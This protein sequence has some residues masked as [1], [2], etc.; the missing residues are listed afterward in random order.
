MD[1]D[2]PAIGLPLSSRQSLPLLLAASLLV[3]CA[4]VAAAVA[5][6]LKPTFY[7]DEGEPVFLAQGGHSPYLQRITTVLGGIHD[8]VEGGKAGPDRGIEG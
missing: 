7:F 8:G 6:G 3:I 2:Q 4:A 1:S 5:Q